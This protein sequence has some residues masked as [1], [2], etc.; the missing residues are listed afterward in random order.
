[1]TVVLYAVATLFFGVALAAAYITLSVNLVA[2]RQDRVNTMPPLAGDAEGFLRALAGASGQRSIRGNA[3]DVYQNGD[4]IFPPMLAA[5]AGST[6]TVHFSSYILW[7]GRIAERFVDAFCEA[8]TR[9]VRVRLI[10]DEE[11]SHG[12]LAPSLVARL[13]AAGCRL[14]WYRRAQWYDIA[15]YNQR[16][17]RRLLVVDGAVGFTGGVGVADQWL[18]NAEGPESWRDVHVRVTGPAVQALQAGFTDNWNQCTDELLLAKCEYPALCE[19]GAIEIMPVISTPTSGASPAQRVTGACIAAATRTLDVTNAYFVPT[20]AFVELLCRAAKRGVTVR[21]LVPGPCHNK[22]LVRRASRHTWSSLIAHGIEIHEHQRTMVHAKT[23][24]VDGLVVLVGSINFDPRSFS[25]NAEAGVVAADRGIASAM[26]MAFQADLAA[27][28]M[29]D[30]AELARLPWWT[31]TG[32]AL[33]YWFR[34]QL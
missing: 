19:A 33:L 23:V 7:S 2:N 10:V 11:G 16:T 20:P 3:V 30:G 24:V 9:G 5:I 21:I 26:E 28:R 22:P 4:A 32:D 14:V 13:R 1:M 31:T 18:G 25:L 6:S 17:H 8:A 27:C 34:G 12:K 15:R 29:V